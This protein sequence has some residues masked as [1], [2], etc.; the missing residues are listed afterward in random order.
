MIDSGA[1]H[2]FIDTALVKKRG[3]HT[4]KHEGIGVQV[5]GGTTLVST[6]KV[7]QLSITVGN[8]TVTDDFYVVDLANSNVILGIQWLITLDKYSQSFKHME[9]SF[10]TNGK[11]VI[12]RGMS[13][14]GPQVLSANIMESIFRH[15]DVA[16]LAQCLIST[17]VTG[18][19]SKHYQDDLLQILDSHSVVFSDIP[20]GV[21]LDRGFEHTIELEEGAKPIITTPYRHPKAFR[22]EIEKAI[23]ELLDM[24]HIRLS[25]SPFASLVVLVKKKDGTLRMCIDYCALKKRPKKPDI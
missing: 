14:G 12:L 21:P 4:V 6:H 15:G 9:F 10:K 2:N 20:P 3:L 22:D 23:K 16:W 1:T 7:P 17:K 8:Y 11:K 19:D 5:A 18:F 24:G 25:S 13:N